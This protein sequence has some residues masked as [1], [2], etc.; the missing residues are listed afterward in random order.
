MAVLIAK[1]DGTLEPFDERKLVN[2]LSHSG[3]D[4]AVAGQIARDITATLKPGTTT[5][6]IYR[7]AFAHLR[8]HKRGIAARYSLKRA[9]LDFGPSGFPFESYLAKLFEAEG[10]HTKV[11]QLI[12]GH[13]V[14]HEVDVVLTKPD[15]PGK[16]IYVEAKFH[17]TAGFKTDLKT[18]LYVQARIEDI[19]ALHPN[20]PERT[21]G[22]V[23]T[24]TKF[25]APAL[26]YSQCRGLEL[27]G[28]EYPHGKNLHDRI[29]AAK[30]YPVTALTS[31]SKKEKINLLSQRLVLCNALPEDTRAL[32]AAGISGKKADEVLEEVGSLC[33]PGVAV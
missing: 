21:A 5:G 4:A 7:R 28:W 24:N 29:E 12:M 14:E 15:T 20:E 6:E 33:I 23:V 13:C 8:E 31:L 16:T 10:W 2:S 25:T 26:Q 32:A 19:A 22:M 3:A 9:V 30:L 11:D 18:V 1:A 17:N 27:L